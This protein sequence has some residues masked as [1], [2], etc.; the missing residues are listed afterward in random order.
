MSTKHRTFYFGH[1]TCLFLLCVCLFIIIVAIHYIFTFLAYNTSTRAALAISSPQW[2]NSKEFVIDIPCVDC[3]KK[4]PT[5]ALKQEGVKRK[6]ISPCVNTTTAGRTGRKWFTPKPVL[7]NADLYEEV[8]DYT[9]YN[10][11]DG[12][13]EDYFTLK[14]RVVNRLDVE[15][16]KT[17]APCHAETYILIVVMSKA[18]HYDRRDIIRKTWQRNLTSRNIQ[19]VFV[20][21]HNSTIFH[22]NMAAWYQQDN[23]IVYT[24]KKQTNATLSGGQRHKADKVR[25]TNNSKKASLVTPMLYSLQ[26]INSHCRN[27]KYVIKAN[28]RTFINIDLMNSFLRQNN[29]T[30]S[31]VGFIQRADLAPRSGPGLVSVDNFPFVYF[32]PYSSGIVYVLSGDLVGPLLHASKHL[33]Y[34]L[35]SDDVYLTGIL[36]RA[37]S[38]RH[39]HHTGLVK[40]VSTKKGSRFRCG[41]HA[42]HA[43]SISDVSRSDMITIYS[44][45]TYT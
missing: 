18:E 41:K 5:L 7:Y 4:Y 13:V 19:V 38:A 34:K 30:R 23:F 40:C 21:Q 25:H 42:H 37:V 27:V 16:I 45:L 3:E 35:P 8:S 39:I 36:A 26:W 33:P 28:D 32:P 15:F 31:I 12:M 11:G 10:E 44:S 29:L 2:R 17:A 22:K 9:V 1:Y 43:L 6:W 20:V 14:R 24:T